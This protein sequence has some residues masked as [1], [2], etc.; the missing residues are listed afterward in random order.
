MERWHQD[1]KPNNILVAGDIK[2]NPY[3]VRFM[4]ADLGLSHFTAVIQ[5]GAGITGE[6][7]G[8]SRAYSK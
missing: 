6:D 8:G 2:T 5:D 7:T 1:I 3:G 4:L